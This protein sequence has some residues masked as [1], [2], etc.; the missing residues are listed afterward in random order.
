MSQTSKQELFH[1]CIFI[2]H[3]TSVNYLTVNQYLPGGLHRRGLRCK[4]TVAD[5]HINFR[6]PRPLKFLPWVGVMIRVAMSIRFVN[7]LIKRKLVAYCFIDQLIILAICKTKMSNICRFNLL[8]CKDLLL[9]DLKWINT[10]FESLSFWSF[11]N[12][13]ISGCR[14][15]WWDF[16]SQFL[17]NLFTIYHNW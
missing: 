3:T 4:A 16:F 15:L 10:F 2:C 5:G 12:L 17:V 1:A 8:K 11:L 7:E 9:C 6:R 13:I 14:K